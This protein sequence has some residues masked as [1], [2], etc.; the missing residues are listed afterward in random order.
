M[1]EKKNPVEKKALFVGDEKK[2]NA[3]CQSV[4]KLEISCGKKKGR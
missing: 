3:A 1:T 4:R 2:D